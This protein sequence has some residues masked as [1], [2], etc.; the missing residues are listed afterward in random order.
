LNT[1]VAAMEQAG[2]RG[3]EQLAAIRLGHSFLLV[4][5]SFTREK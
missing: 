1:V 5:K 2:E 4:K 3:D